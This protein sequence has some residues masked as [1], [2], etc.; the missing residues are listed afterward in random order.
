VG[1]RLLTRGSSRQSEAGGYRIENPGRP[2]GRMQICWFG[3]FGCLVSSPP[4]GSIR[5]LFTVCSFKPDD[6]LTT[7][8]LYCHHRQEEL[9]THQY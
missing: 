9:L 8:Q 7:L 3:S 5:A 6:V 2:A 4:D 1:T